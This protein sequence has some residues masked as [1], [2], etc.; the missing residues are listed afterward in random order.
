MKWRLIN[1]QDDN[2]T[3]QT[4]N[5]R[6]FYIRL[7]IRSNFPLTLYSDIKKQVILTR[8]LTE[9]TSFVKKISGRNTQMEKINNLEHFTRSDRFV[10]T[11]KMNFKT[12]KTGQ[13]I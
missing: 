12:E 4:S 5:V 8:T 10:K 13:I 2:I 1:V 11:K 3:S 9:V 7:I 6:T